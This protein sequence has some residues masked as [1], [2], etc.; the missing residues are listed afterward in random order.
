MNGPIACAIDDDII[1]A[2]RQSKATN[3][4]AMYDISVVR[5]LRRLGEDVRLVTATE[6][7]DRTL[8]ELF[9]VK[10]SL[11]FNLAFS[12]TPAEPIFAGLLE[13]LGIPYT[14]SGAFAI[15]LSRDKIRSRQL[16]QAE[17]IAVPPFV[18][19][20][21][22]GRPRTIGLAPPYIVKPNNLANSLG[23]RAGSVVETYPEVL[24]LADGIWRRFA[25]PSI[26]DTFIAGREFQVG[27]IERRGAFEI[28]AIVE[29]FFAGAPPGRGFKSE[30]VTFQGRRR[31]VYEVI[32]RA[33]RLPRASAAEMGAIARRAA[34][35]L[36]FRG[37]AK[38]DVRM[39]ERG[40]IFVLEAN[41]NPGLWSG[42]HVW[43]RGG[44]GENLRQ[45]VA[46]GRR[47]ARQ[48]WA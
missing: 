38:I 17:G 1:A 10:P 8:R 4:R 41:A 27:L 36:G 21:R 30:S 48:E 15:A 19:L 37:Y 24:A 40:R 22:R 6:P 33:A 29:L 42:L 34:E 23:I 31:R 25:L 20:P 18:V 47:R 7:A 43:R 13:V 11:V 44:F 28:T 39:D 12:V 5:A 3:R 32:V 2:V 14:G 46:A 45:I 26:C 35:V 9:E 16:L